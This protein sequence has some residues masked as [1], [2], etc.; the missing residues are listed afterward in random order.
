MVFEQ[1]LPPPVCN[2][3]ATAHIPL[4]EHVKLLD[5]LVVCRLVCR[6][7][8]GIIEGKSLQVLF[9]R[10]AY[11]A[12]E[13]GPVSRDVSRVKWKYVKGIVV[14]KA[15]GIESTFD[16]VLALF[17]NVA[18]VSWTCEISCDNYPR[19]VSYPLLQHLSR[20]DWKFSGDFENSLEAFTKLVQ[21]SPALEYLTIVEVPEAP[22]LGDRSVEFRIPDSVKT[23]GVFCHRPSVWRLLRWVIAN[24]GRGQGLEHV[25]TSGEYPRFPF[26]TVELRPDPS[27]TT[28]PTKSAFGDFVRGCLPKNGTTGGTLIYSCTAYPPVECYDMIPERSGEW[29]DKIILKTSGSSYRSEEDEWEV[30]QRHLDFVSRKF[31]NLASVDL[32]DDFQEWKKDPVK[33]EVFEAFEESAQERGI[34]VE[35]V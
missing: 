6:R 13:D 17:P 28:R 4:Q 5:N 9:S 34:I 25:I 33:R 29:V 12:T 2:T 21:H 35:Y 32:H 3:T 22:L 26:S 11:H 30:V 16:S 7:W 15:N 8:K 14:R 31:R 27:S 20:L 1:F 18:Y 24:W 23:L 10:D 19:H